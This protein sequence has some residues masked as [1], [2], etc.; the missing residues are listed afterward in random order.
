MPEIVK[1]RG[2]IKVGNL[3]PSLVA[4]LLPNQEAAG[5]SSAIALERALALQASL[6]N[7]SGVQARN[8]LRVASNVADGETVTIGTNVFEVDPITTDTTRTCAGLNNT[9]NPVLLTLSGAP[10][11]VIAAGDLVRVENEICKVLR[12]NSTTQ[13]VLARAR[14]GTTIATH[15]DATA[16]FQSAAAPAANIPVG[17][18]VTLT[19]VVF[20][21]ALV[22]EINNALA[23]TERATAKASTIFD[24]GATFPDSQRTGKVVASIFTNEMFVKSAIAEAMVLATTE[25]LAGA[26]N[27]W[28]TV[29]MAQGLAAVAKKRQRVVI[30]PNAQEVALGFI[31]IPVPFT[32]TFVAVEVRTTASGIVVAWNGGAVPSAGL[33]TID[34][35]GAT[36]W[37]ATDTLYVDIGE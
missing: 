26:N 22:A 34:N 10:G 33:V 16:V 3:S 9:T 18:N 36:D 35:A 17:V 19:P 12:K 37:A 11:I 30:V 32:P 25:T 29:T 31:R 4:R 14:A 8:S 7:L 15:A 24:P 21:A 1:V 13:Y 2:G 20:I 27:A 5:L 28:S 23:G 6:V